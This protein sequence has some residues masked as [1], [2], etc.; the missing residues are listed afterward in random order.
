M[1]LWEDAELTSSYGHSKTRL[2]MGQFPP[3]K[4]AKLAQLFHRIK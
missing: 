3:K 4:T 1:A 2:P